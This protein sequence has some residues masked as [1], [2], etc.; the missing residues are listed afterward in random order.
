M[1]TI[2]AD[3]FTDIPRT[4]SYGNAGVQHVSKT[5]AAN[6][7]ADELVL[8]ELPAGTKL[9]DFRAVIAAL[10]ASTTLSF[11]WRYKNGEAG[12]GAAALEAAASTVSASTVRG[13][14]VPVEF[15]FD[16]YVTATIGGGA[17]TGAVNVV[18]NYE[19]LGTL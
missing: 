9:H 11:G 8:I 10:G 13:T 18:L 1:A 14:F 12:G 15:E 17:A 3:N 16:A 7:I 5:L 19:Y 6:P 2:F 4:G